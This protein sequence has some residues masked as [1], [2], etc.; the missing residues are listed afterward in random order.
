MRLPN[1][2]LAEVIFELRWK[3]EGVPGTPPGFPF[4]NDPG[5]PIFARIF[6]EKATKQG[7]PIKESARPGEVA[8][9][10]Y[11]TRE[12]FKRAADKPFPVL[13]IG[14]GVFACNASTE[15]EWPLFK[16]LIAEGLELVFDSY[17]ITEVTR[18]DLIGCE[19]RYLDVFDQSLLGHLDFLKFFT[20]NTN[21]YRL[22]LPFLADELLH[23]ETSGQLNI[24][25]GVA[26]DKETRFHFEVGT[27]ESPSAKGLV[28]W[29]KV[30]KNSDSMK[31]DEAKKEKIGALLSWAES[32][33][34]VTHKFFHGFV[35]QNLMEKFKTVK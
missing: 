14:P 31:L 1:A 6:S 26:F 12:R 11:M 16:A 18:H 24:E 9:I 27:G 29:S 28:A 8:P 17:P 19:L 20:E 4:G 21:G 22:D 5:Y 34:D 13:Q 35:A 3:V 32:A 23:G 25:K 10:A 7:F 2:P 30:T 15:Y 33:H